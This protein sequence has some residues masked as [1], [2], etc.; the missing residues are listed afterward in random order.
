MDWLIDCLSEWVSYGESV[1]LSEW[2]WLIDVLN[3]C[4]SRW[5]SE[6]VIETLNE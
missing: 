5:V 3:E 1:Q 4:I 6:G 2:E